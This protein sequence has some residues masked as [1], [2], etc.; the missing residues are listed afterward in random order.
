MKYIVLLTLGI[1]RGVRTVMCGEIFGD[2]DVARL[3]YD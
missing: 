3:E 2:V 1:L